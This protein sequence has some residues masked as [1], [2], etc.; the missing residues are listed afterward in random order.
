MFGWDSTV[1]EERRDS[2]AVSAEAVVFHVVAV[3]VLDVDEV[4]LAL[5]VADGMVPL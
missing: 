5:V 3:V 2:V 4:V 1:E